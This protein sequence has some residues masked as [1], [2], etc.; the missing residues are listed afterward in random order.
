MKKV[1]FLIVGSGYRAEFYG[2][3]VLEQGALFDAMFLCRSKEK[4]ALLREKLGL[5][6]TA[7][8]EEALAFAPDFAVVVVNKAGLASVTMEWARLGVPV[9]SETPA[10]STVEEL[11]ALWALRDCKI[12]V[13]EQYHRYPPIAAGLAAIRAGRI[14]TPTSAV[15]SLAHDYHGASLLRRLLLTEG[16]RFTIRGVGLTSPIVETDS[17]AGPITDGRIGQ[18]ERHLLHVTY[19]SGKWGLY[20]FCHVQ[21]RSFIRS[22]HLLVRGE[23]GE[24]CDDQLL[25]LDAHNRPQREQLLPLTMARS[26]DTE[27]VTAMLLAMADYVQGGPEPYPLR[28][29][30]DDAYFWLLSQEALQTPWTAVSSA[31]MPWQEA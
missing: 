27:A 31:P 10:G 8:R 4:A 28:E 15:L 30:L 25:T 5:P 12:A 21:Y 19:A 22:R 17:R 14:G 20:D 24:W 9:L 13:S 3:L 18:R 1:R 6:A 16:E 2:R 23:R 29:A 11:K 7:S 26:Q